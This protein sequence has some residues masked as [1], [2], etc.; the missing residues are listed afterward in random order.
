MPFFRRHSNGFQVVIDRH[1]LE[2]GWVICCLVDEQFIGLRASTLDEAKDLADGLAIVSY[3]VN[4]D[5][6]C[7][8]WEF[9]KS[10]HHA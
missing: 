5:P 7:E 10:K 6:A 2:G 1:L 4:C 9:L 3:L 8:E